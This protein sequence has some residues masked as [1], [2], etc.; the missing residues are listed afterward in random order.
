MPETGFRELPTR[1]LGIALLYAALIGFGFALQRL[2]RTRARK[3][4][5]APWWFGYARDLT[6]L[7]A[8][9]VTS[10]ALGL[11]GFA[12]P[13]AL[14]YGF[15]VTLATYLA[16]YA[17]SHGLSVHRASALATLVGFVCAAPLVLFPARCAEAVSALLSYL[18]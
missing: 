2:R 15:V 8:L 18:F 14:L 10:L 11:A 9:L 5:G 12:P 3:A 16:D 7:L 13:L 1:P 17:L 4:E 6:N